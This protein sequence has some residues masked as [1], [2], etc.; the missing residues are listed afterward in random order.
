M[1]R[2]PILYSGEPVYDEIKFR[3][4]EKMITYIMRLIV[5]LTIVFF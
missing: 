3:D 1:S 4:N 5:S 2:K